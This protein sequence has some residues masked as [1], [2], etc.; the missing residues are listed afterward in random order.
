[1]EGTLTCT[2]GS[3]AQHAHSLEDHTR[4]IQQSTSTHNK[5]FHNIQQEN[6]NDNIL[7]IDSPNFN[8]RV[9]HKTNSSINRATHKIQGHNITLNT[10]QV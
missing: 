7:R 8:K 10:T 9:T 2:L 3:Q 5:H 1:M 4:S 6:N